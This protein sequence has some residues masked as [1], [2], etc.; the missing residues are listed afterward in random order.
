MLG[1]II[2]VGKTALMNQYYSK[3]FVN[4][5]KPTIGADFITK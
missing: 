3:K 2:R 1:L 5:Y 4:T